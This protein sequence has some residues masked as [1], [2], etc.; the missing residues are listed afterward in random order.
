MPVDVLER[1]R[2]GKGDSPPATLR[3]PR[4][5]ISLILLAFALAAADAAALP[6]ESPAKGIAA[7]T[8]PTPPASVTATP[9]KETST[10]AAVLSVTSHAPPLVQGRKSLKQRKPTGK[11]KSPNHAL[12][13]K[14][15]LSRWE[16]EDARMGAAYT[17]ESWRDSAATDEDH[18]GSGYPRIPVKVKKGGG[19]KRRSSDEGESDMYYVRL[20]PIHQYYSPFLH[21]HPEAEDETSA[22]YGATIRKHHHHHHRQEEN[23]AISARTNDDGPSQ[24]INIRPLPY[25]H[26]ASATTHHRHH[27]VRR[28]PLS[29]QTNGKPGPVYHWNLPILRGE[30]EGKRGWKKVYGTK[31]GATQ[32]AHAIAHKSHPKSKPTGESP[33]A[34]SPTATSSTSTTAFPLIE[35]DVFHVVKTVRG[36]VHPMAVPPL[37]P[38]VPG[39]HHRKPY[40]RKPLSS[41]SATAFPVTSYY[42]RK[43]TKG[44]P[45]PS[46]SRDLEHHTAEQKSFFQGNGKP[47]GFYVIN[48]SKKYYH[49]LLP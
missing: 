21:G 8:L 3:F 40:H 47:H 18:S 9:A 30:D 24:I 38:R 11:K 25:D 6:K 33:T 35:S 2:G 13:T 22:R 1:W 16:G 26:D 28:L 36:R 41:H 37:R 29:F 39:S 12:L 19:G 48:G 43:G 49:R 27:T 34:P 14:F 15:G 44:E 4:M 17:S 46:G 7:A 32:S 31:S 5:A 42:S 45:S 20:P 23:E 10:I